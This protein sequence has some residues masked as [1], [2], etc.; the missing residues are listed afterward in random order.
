MG[1]CAVAVHHQATLILMLNIGDQAP[2]FSLK[3]LDGTAWHY[4]GAVTGQPVLMVFFETDC[5]TCHLTIPYLNRL[6]SAFREDAVSIIGI[7]QDG[8][9]LTRELVEQMQ[10]TFPVALDADL[11]VS[12]LYSPLA[13]PTLLLLDRAGKVIRTQIGFDKE[14]LNDIAAAMSEAAGREPMLIAERADGAP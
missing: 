5:P 4:A 9:E 11:N 2:N 7:S 10:G 14:A 8:A 3:R 1:W 6:A 12:R 13:V